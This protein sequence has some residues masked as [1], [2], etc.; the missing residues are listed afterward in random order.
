MTTAHIVIQGRT[1][2]PALV[3]QVAALAGAAR[4]RQL[5]DTAWRCEAMPRTP[6]AALRARLRDLGDAAQA[7]INIVATPR[8]LATYRL[9]VMDMDSTLITIECIDEIA[10]MMGIKPQVA[11]I[12]EAAMRGE[13]EYPESLRRR[14][15]LLAGLNVAA[16]ERVYQERLRLSPGAEQLIAGFKSAGLKTMLVSGGF[17]FFTERV[18]HRLALDF[19]HS[20]VL[21]VADGKLTGRVTG[22]LVDAQEKARKLAATCAALGCSPADSIAIGDGANDLKMMGVAGVS[23]AYRAKPIVCAQAMASI[24]HNGLD[25]VLKLF[26]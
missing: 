13:I 21:D 24:S 10:D 12:T 17:T 4:I 1:L 20:N 9:A 3:Q 6:G 8:P 16:L 19:A 26:D 22:V 23:V 25:A 11:A 14:V 15:A 7:D 5:C 2:T 18:Q